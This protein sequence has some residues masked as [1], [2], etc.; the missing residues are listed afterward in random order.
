MNKDIKVSLYLQKMQ[1][2]DLLNK[3]GNALDLG[4]G[5]GAD[6]LALAQMGYEVDSV[7]SHNERIQALKEKIGE[8][9]IRAVQVDIRD[10]NIDREKYSVIICSNVLSFLKNKEEIFTTIRK[11]SDGLVP[12]GVMYFTVFGPHDEWADN[13]EMMFIEYED[14]L[15]FLNDLPLKIYH[16]STEEGYGKKMDGTIK[17]WHIH[18]FFCVKK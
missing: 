12:Q 9:N 4:C 7:D 18:R 10:F 5:A 11:M 6:S 13:K 2:E 1:S 16:R 8:L 14:V 3:K 15:K 17:Y